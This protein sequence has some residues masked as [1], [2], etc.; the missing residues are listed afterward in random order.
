MILSLRVANFRGFVGKKREFI[1]GRRA[2]LGHGCVTS[3]VGSAGSGKSSVVSALELLQTIARGA[4][5]TD[6]L[7]GGDLLAVSS[8]L[9]KPCEI[10][11]KFEQQGALFQYGFKLESDE[12]E[13]CWRIENEWLLKGKPDGSRLMPVFARTGRLVKIGGDEAVRGSYELDTKVFVLATFATIDRMHP[14]FRTKSYLANLLIFGDK[15][16]YV[17]DSVPT[18]KRPCYLASRAE[19][20]GAWLAYQI[21]N[22]AGFYRE[23]AAVLSR[24]LPRFEKLVVADEPNT[25]N[26]LALLLK[27]RGHSEE[28]RVVPLWMLSSSE[29]TIFLGAIMVT[30]CAV[31][32]SA[33]CVCD[34]FDA[35]EESCPTLAAEI[36]R[37]IS[38]R[39]QLIAFHKRNHKLYQTH[40]VRIAKEGNDVQ[41]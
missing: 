25:G 41:S 34:D 39:K 36:G 31:F 1:L 9:K 6:Q 24:Y 38:G 8:D 29:R 16:G 13:R 14:L 15:I 21:A 32:V 7:H 4:R 22:Q 18:E 3:V 27:A 23:F 30:A 12:K 20:L 28:G 11:I 26:H 40:S 19:N 35:I 37:R 10:V 2:A 33:D 5:S 17:N